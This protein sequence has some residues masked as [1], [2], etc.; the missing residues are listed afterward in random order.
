MHAERDYLVKRVFPELQD[1][2][3]RRKLRLVDVDLR[4]GVT[5]QD[6]THK[7][8]VNVCLNRIDDC[9]PFFVCF[10]GQRRG[11]VP[12][13]DEIST[14]TYDSLPELRSVVGS[15]SI[16]EMEI[17]HALISPFHQSVARDPRRT[18]E[19]Y[20]RAKYAFFY[21]RSPSYL[22]QLPNDPFQLREIYTND[23]VE[24]HEGRQKH[25]AALTRW[26][27]QE[28]QNTN[29]PFHFYEAS[30]NPKAITP[31]L[32]IPLQSPSSDSIHCESWASQWRRAGVRV[33]GLNI[34]DPVEAEKA[35]KFNE[36]LSS[37]RLTDFRCEDVSLHDVITRE[38]QE[39]IAAQ[40]PT[41]SEI[42]REGELQRE[43][44]QQDLF[45][46]TATEGFIEREGDFAEL[47][48]YVNGDSNQLFVITAPGGMGK[49]TLLAKWIDLYRQRIEPAGHSIHF[50]F[51]GQSN[52]TTS[53]DSLLRL[54]LGEIKETTNK[55]D[56]DI[57]LDPIDLRNN[58]PSLLEK[59]GTRGKTV[60]VI[61]SLN[62]L[63][64]GLAEVEWLP[65]KLPD[66][67]KVI[68]SFKDDAPGAEQFFE[69]LKR[70]DP[71][72]IVRV[73]PFG[74]LDDRRRLVRGYLSQYLKE[75][76]DHQLET[77]INLPG[78]QNP[79]YLKVVLS[80]LR[81][82]GTPHNLTEKIQSDFG[83]NPVSAFVQ[84]LR[85]LEQDPAYTQVD[86]RS[87]VPLLFGF[88]AHARRG[89]SVEE[90]TDL[91]VR[92]LRLE[93]PDQPREIA[94]DTVHLFLR[95]VRGFLARR[96]GRY[97]FFYE[98]FKQAALQYFRIPKA[99]APELSWHELLATYFRDLPAYLVIPG[100]EEFRKPN[101]RKLDEQ[102][103]Q[104]LRARKWNELR[105][106]LCNLEFVEAKVGAGLV[107]ALVA[108]FEA[109]EREAPPD[110]ALRDD[111]WVEW[112]QF[113]NL[114]AHQF[115]R[116][117]KHSPTLVLQ[118]ALNQP[119]EGL[120]HPAA[121]AYLKTRERTHEY[122]FQRKNL[123]KWFFPSVCLRI[124]V[125][126]VEHL[127]AE[128]NHAVSASTDGVLEYWDINTGAVI[129]TMVHL[130]DRIWKIHPAPNE[131]LVL[132]DHEGALSVFDLVSG[133]LLHTRQDNHP[134]PPIAIEGDRVVSAAVV[135]GKIMAIEWDLQ[136]GAVRRKFGEHTAALRRVW[137]QSVHRL[138]TESTDDTLHVWDRV[139]GRS[140]TKIHHPGVNQLR[141]EVVGEHAV[142]IGSSSATT[143][144]RE[145]H[146]RVWDLETGICR[147]ILECEFGAPNR[148]TPALDG[149]AIC[150]EY[151][152]ALVVWELASGRRISTI[153]C[154]DGDV[155]VLALTPDQRMAI[156]KDGTDQLAVFDLSSGK[157]YRT[158]HGAAPEAPVLV[159][160]NLVVS[161]SATHDLHVWQFDSGVHLR[162]MRGHTAKLKHLLPAR[163]NQVMSASE[164][165]TVRVWDLEAARSRRSEGDLTARGSAASLLPDGRAA[166]LAEGAV[167]IWNLTSGEQDSKLG[168]DRGR[169][170][171][172]EATEN[173]LLVTRSTDDA[174][175]V[176]QLASSECLHV[177]SGHTD[178]INRL[179]LLSNERAVSTSD[180]GTLR[181]WDLA[182]GTG[183]GNPDGH[184]GAI[185][186]LVRLPGNKA[187][188]GGA[189][190]EL[191]FWDLQ[192][193][194]CDLNLK[195]YNGPM[196][197]IELL[198]QNR[199]LTVGPAGDLFRDSI[200]I[201]DLAERKPVRSFED[202]K[203]FYVAVGEDDQLAVAGW[204]RE[205]R[206]WDL[207]T[208][209]LKQTLE[210]FTKNY[211]TIS[212]IRIDASGRLLADCSDKQPHAWSMATGQY[213]G[214]VP[215]H[216][217]TGDESTSGSANG[218]TQCWPNQDSLTWVSADRLKK[219]V[220][221]LEGRPEVAWDNIN[222]RGLLIEA[223]SGEIHVLQISSLSELSAEERPDGSKGELEIPTVLSS[224][225]VVEEER[226][227]QKSD[228]DAKVGMVVVAVTV[229][230]GVVL[231]FIWSWL[232]WIIAPLA[233]VGI[234]LV[235]V[236]VLQMYSPPK[237]ENAMDLLVLAAKHRAEGNLVAA[238][239]LLQR[240][241]GWCRK[242][243][244]DEP[245]VVVLIE[246]AGVFDELKQPDEVMRCFQEA[247]PIAKAL[248]NI[249][250]YQLCVVGQYLVQQTHVAEA[251][252]DPELLIP[253]L[254]EVEEAMRSS[255]DV[256]G[257]LVIAAERSRLLHRLGRHEDAISDAMNATR[258]SNANA[259]ALLQAIGQNLSEED[260]MSAVRSFENQSAYL[261]A[262]VNAFVRQNPTNE[263][264]VLEEKA[265]MLEKIGDYE[266]SLETLVKITSICEARGD[267]AAFGRSL[268]NQAYI[269]GKLGRVAEAS[270][271]FDRAADLARNAGDSSL[272]TCLR[273]HALV[274]L[275]N[276]GD[277][278]RA[279]ALVEEAERSEEERG[280]ENELL[281][282]LDL[283]AQIHLRRE[284]HARELD[285]IEK[286]ISRLRSTTNRDAD[287]IRSLR[288]KTVAIR[289][290]NVDT[291]SA[292]TVFDEMADLCR[293][294]GDEYNLAIAIS[295]KGTVLG[296][297]LGSKAEGIQHLHE[298]R[299]IFRR[300]GKTQEIGQVDKVVGWIEQTPDAE[301]EQERKPQHE[302][303]QATRLLSV[304]AGISETEAFTAIAGG[305]W[306]RAL[307]LLLE[308][309]G[310]HRS[311]GNKEDLAV[312]LAVKAA[313]LAQ[314][315]TDVAEAV[316]LIREAT[317]IVAVESR[318]NQI[319]REALEIIVDVAD[320]SSED[321]L[322][323]G[324][325]DEALNHVANAV[326]LARLLNEPER[327]ARLLT[328][329]AILLIEVLDRR[330][331]SVPLLAEIEQLAQEHGLKEVTDALVNIRN[332]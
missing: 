130:G 255:G 297:S 310:L 32:A 121:R 166:V 2:C 206:I 194:S 171:G 123:Q 152:R 40:F 98:S 261:E 176:W 154:Y 179:L 192:N 160:D 324:R 31:E 34:D 3:E 264:A 273:S 5:E 12:K 85:R 242:A 167:Q 211:S 20:K 204:A 8:A 169:I 75:L 118:Q 316:K 108:D 280:D 119:R 266:G 177:L 299:T 89:L 268:N 104:E 33:D 313:L 309:E 278:D 120:I 220:Y 1:W 290:L 44:D 100:S 237:P 149:I 50:R 329:Q 16:T 187:I 267:K 37:G 14:E 186:H 251:D 170:E 195:A 306:P 29:R 165:G 318:M 159:P 129:R 327:L 156:C 95:Q 181:V 91:L 125:R 222:N 295:E 263:I 105:Q 66:N 22:N 82:F 272:G 269:T 83:D 162:T 288:R 254:Q 71:V 168:L 67:I 226:K 41:H 185:T 30:W 320:R 221:P 18:V 285:V 92:N 328:G 205:L 276:H 188:T 293:R 161:A 228:Q 265:R 93:G 270:K 131:R 111:H 229:F 80:E 99:D 180:D 235:V 94:A 79:L 209:L 77:L 247:A 314:S 258:A 4:W 312:V 139:S 239:E 321:A 46:F 64:S 70:G 307:K 63:E 7:N 87:A 49:S 203:I 253:L 311:S 198:A 200:K 182:N 127:A 122:I 62:Q 52:G 208:G 26:R 23:W 112:R 6:A 145:E 114:E 207:R 135:E 73:K 96:E 61:D 36:R 45:L 133:Q 248:G 308:R 56:E 230:V 244:A 238:V 259:N 300:L 231:A 113:V 27:E 319:I 236:G 143:N 197:N 102:P 53:I 326:L 157:A 250:R 47:D 202:E 78:A 103:W 132:A 110:S 287:L 172:F 322:E 138:I 286:V 15:A 281:H 271:L 124:H 289:A 283:Q 58:W 279:L 38:L 330:E 141:F 325:T 142:S 184:A 158:L 284:N 332:N 243:N 277:L 315:D 106:T 232:W 17:L 74:E 134:R 51:I 116:H 24:N 140:I 252:R 190:G 210:H 305:G 65:R 275:D 249:K 217:R 147:H 224:P 19:Y 84:M 296:L 25:D 173:G 81:M 148:V 241:A 109:A 212:G 303:L 225:Y 219:A 245:L 214:V 68:A 107:R 163:P 76:D 189:D 137:I 72:D 291:A 13:L 39:A 298:A 117:I 9:R 260:L 146:L 128:G 43:L 90:L 42:E 10:L 54:V 178:R 126:Q 48:A 155:R 223:H 55:L 11:W 28:I 274:L 331:E 256:G 234:F 59:I 21:L 213:L 218:P 144:S 86:P 57:P 136:S 88:L 227:K 191:R 262:A 150:V 35:R 183:I 215:N 101:F 151:R 175:R 193:G 301:P 196:R 233:I 216:T 257:A 282:S 153:T 69:K 292:L 115:E 304:A 317:S 323:A 97:D 294:T 246:L 201:W 199:L 302:L 174:I 240:A 60:I 164:D